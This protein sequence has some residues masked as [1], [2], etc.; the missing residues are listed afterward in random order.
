MEDRVKVINNQKYDIG[1]VTVGKP[2]GINIRPGSFAVLTRE[3]V[4]YLCSVCT[5]FQSGELRIS[6]D[7]LEKEVLESVGI[8]KEENA[9]FADEED[10]RKHLSATNKKVEE[11]LDGVTEEHMLDRI[12][13]IAQ[14]MNLSMS[15]VKLLK[16]K[17]PNKN[18]LGE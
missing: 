10:I 13:D 12:F 17:M 3:D 4:E 18:F 7:E 14:D 11:W 9:N 6:D 15:K 8:S 2:Q 1:I 5:L 16:A